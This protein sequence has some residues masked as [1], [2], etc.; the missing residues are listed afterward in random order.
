MSIRQTAV[1]NFAGEKTH[2]KRAC[3]RRILSK[4]LTT[5]SPE[6]SKPTL[7]PTKMRVLEK[8]YFDIFTV[9]SFE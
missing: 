2:V 8:L 6:V 4:I 3:A 1:L 9:I 5:A 7:C